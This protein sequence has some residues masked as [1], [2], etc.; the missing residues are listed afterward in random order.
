M[1]VI[2]E[3]I[4]EANDFYNKYMPRDY[5]NE[6]EMRRKQHKRHMAGKYPKTLRRNKHGY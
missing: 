5:I 6:E 4:A 1:K 3:Y 2:N